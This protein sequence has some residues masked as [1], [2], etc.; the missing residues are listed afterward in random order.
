[1]KPT[2]TLLAL[3]MTS[4]LFASAVQAIPTIAPSDYAITT[5]D[6]LAVT[7]GLDDV[8]STASFDDDGTSRTA[9][10]TDKFRI[11]VQRIAGEGTTAPTG[12]DWKY[13][14][15]N[16]TTAPAGFSSIT[17][18]NDV[19]TLSFENLESGF[20]QIKICQEGTFTVNA[21]TETVC[22]SEAADSSRTYFSV[23]TAGT[24]NNKIALIDNTLTRYAEHFATNASPGDSNAFKTLA[25]ATG[26]LESAAILGE[27][28]SYYA[29][30]TAVWLEVNNYNYDLLS[31]KDL[32]SANALNGYDAVIIAGRNAVWDQDSLN[33]IGSYTNTADKGIMYLGAD[34]LSYLATI[35]DNTLNVTARDGSALTGL[36]NSFAGETESTDGSYSAINNTETSWVFGD[37][38][39]ANGAAFGLYTSTSTSID[40]PSKHIVGWTTDGYESGSTTAAET[41]T[42]AGDDTYHVIGQAT[43][44][45]GVATPGYFKAGDGAMVFNAATVRWAEGLSD[46][47]EGYAT[48]DGAVSTITKTVL[49]TF[50][51]D[52]TGAE[53]SESATAVNTFCGLEAPLTCETGEELNAASTECVAVVL[54]CETGEELNAAGTACVTTTPTTP[55][56]G[57]GEEL[58]TTTNTCDA[59]E[60]EEEEAT[61]SSGGGAFGLGLFGIFGLMGL[62]RRIR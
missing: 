22:I 40:I 38:S 7:L 24:T 32:A 58:N 11:E 19:A 16:G 18:T 51:T 56:C 2:K 52:C 36:R 53:Y 44:F 1:M 17:T 34:N 61:K 43:A 21:A 3:S 13:G 45:N 62:R 55:T 30:A 6:S 33:A 25:S 10:L 28:G 42:T 5:N 37:S 49:D 15:T 59:V 26:N 20:Y 50:L 12:L 46:R 14:Y 35:S 47:D 31:Y 41:F 4:A 48:V 39:L 29:A 23:R 9:T 57:T 27:G 8:D 60:G 54:T